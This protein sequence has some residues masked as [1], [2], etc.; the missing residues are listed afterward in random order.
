MCFL[1]C[2]NKYLNASVFA[3]L[4]FV[5]AAEEIINFVN[6]QRTFWKGR[7]CMTW[8]VSYM[9]C[10]IRDM[11]PS[12]VTHTRILCSA[13]NPSKCTHTQQWVVNKQTNT[14]TEQWPAILCCGARGAVGGSVLCSRV[15]PQSWYW[16]WRERWLFTP[17]NPCRT[18][19]S[20]PRPLGYKSD[21]LSI[22]PRLPPFALFTYLS[23]LPGTCN[24]KRHLLALWIWSSLMRI[25]LCSAKHQSCATV[26]FRFYKHRKQRQVWS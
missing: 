11:W 25:S 2:Y 18:W 15:S 1:N 23:G 4:H 21:S 13:F 8:H 14:H 6:M 7:P 17:P 16:E 26:V 19:D 9:A 24:R 22:R 10:V 5:E 12:M 20:N 3:L